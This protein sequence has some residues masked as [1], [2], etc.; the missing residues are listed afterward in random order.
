MIALAVCVM[1]LLA[2]TGHTWTLEI[3]YTGPGSE[4]A[5]LEQEYHRHENERSKERCE[6]GCATGADWDRAIEWDRDNG[7]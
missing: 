3:E 7:A 5:R 1:T 6:Q 4:A 2:I